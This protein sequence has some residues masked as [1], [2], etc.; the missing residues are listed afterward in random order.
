MVR[1]AAVAPGRVREVLR[2]VAQLPHPRVVEVGVWRGDMSAALLRGNIEL[3]LLMVDPWEDPLTQPPIRK[4]GRQPTQDELYR[5]AVNVTAWAAERREVLQMRSVDAAALMAVQS[6]R[7]DLVFIDG[8]HSYE[9]VRADIA[10]WAPLLEPGGW[11]G[12]H[13]Y[14]DAGTPGVRMAVDEAVREHGW[15]LERGQDATWWVR[16]PG[17]SEW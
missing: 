5:R 12:G 3:Q 7:F 9:A 16:I 4:I 6:R 15:K 13:D 1:Q 17:G 14:Y 11:L 10:A 2:R 8:D